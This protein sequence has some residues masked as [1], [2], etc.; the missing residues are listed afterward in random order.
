MLLSEEQTKSYLNEMIQ[1]YGEKEIQEI[2]TS[3]NVDMLI[4]ASYRKKAFE[5]MKIVLFGDEW[6]ERKKGT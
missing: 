4:E 6:D 2:V 3:K 1:H 5:D